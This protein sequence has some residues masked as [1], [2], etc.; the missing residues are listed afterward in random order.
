M[1]KTSE[2]KNLFKIVKDM[3][4]CHGGDYVFK[5]NEWTPIIK[6]ASICSKGWHLTTMPY[7]WFVWGCSIF[8]SEAKNIIGWSEDKCVCD[9]IRLL[10]EIPKPVWQSKAED[11]VSDIKDGKVPFFVPDGVPDKSWKI[12]YGDTWSAARGAALDA[13]L[14]SSLLICSDLKLAKKHKTHIEKRWNAWKKGY[15][16][17]CDVEGVLYVYAVK[18][19]KE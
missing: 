14:Y 12:F 6:D 4:S 5:I 15:G 11:F 16:V 17:L 18:K 19:K 8:E 1:K 10:R 13:A 3:K 2:P 9:S 7:K